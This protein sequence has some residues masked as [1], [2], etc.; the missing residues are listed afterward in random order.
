SRRRHSRLVSDWIRD[1]CSSDLSSRKRSRGTAR[2][3][4]VTNRC[5]EAAYMYAIIVSVAVEKRL[6][7]R[8]FT[9]RPP[10]A[11]VACPSSARA[12]PRSEEH[13]SEL[14]SLTNTVC[15]LLL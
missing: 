9:T 5:S 8:P 2:L 1:V 15:R 14:Q 4:D 3:F 6:P 7:G 11:A 12:K 13:T 10:A